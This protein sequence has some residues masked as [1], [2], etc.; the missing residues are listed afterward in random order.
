VPLKIGATAHKALR[1]D[2]LDSIESS[3]GMP[4]GLM[5][6]STITKGEGLKCRNSRASCAANLVNDNSETSYSRLKV[7]HEKIS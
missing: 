4:H 3:P 1:S 5:M 7:K 2:A 6:R